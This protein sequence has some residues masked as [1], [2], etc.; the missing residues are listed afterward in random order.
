M[1]RDECIPGYGDEFYSYK[2]EGTDIAGIRQ[3]CR[4]FIHGG[5]MGYLPDILIGSGDREDREYALRS[6]N[7]MR[8]G[9]ESFRSRDNTNMAPNGEGVYCRFIP[10]NIGG[11]K[12]LM[13]TITGPGAS[14]GFFFCIRAEDAVDLSFYT[15]DSNDMKY[16]QVNGYEARAGGL[17][18][19]GELVGRMCEIAREVRNQMRRNGINNSEIAF[20]RKIPLEKVGEVLLLKKICPK[21]TRMWIVEDKSYEKAYMAIHNVL[22]QRRISH[23]YSRITMLELLGELL[24]RRG[25]SFAEEFCVQQSG[26]RLIY[27]RYIRPSHNLFRMSA[28]PSMSA[29]ASEPSTSSAHAEPSS[30]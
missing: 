18:E 23:P 14:G 13:K 26:K 15:M 12:N 25:F 1:K 8:E 22:P 30:L 9:G 10:M 7:L 29:E 6:S 27:Q 20:Y 21:D 5:K 3:E 16:S 2:I 19:S 28:A 4:G 24:Q 17:D 11:I